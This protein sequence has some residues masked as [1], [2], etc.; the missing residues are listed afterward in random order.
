MAESSISVLDTELNITLDKFLKV[1]WADNDFWRAV[2]KEQG[3]YDLEWGQYAW[4]LLKQQAFFKSRKLNIE[5][6]RNQK[7]Q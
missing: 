2:Q 3:L 1:M 7:F 5:L 6:Q 4:Q